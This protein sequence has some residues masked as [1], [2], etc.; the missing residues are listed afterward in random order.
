[1]ELSARSVRHRVAVAGADAEPSAG[2]TDG[3]IDI[4][5][6]F[7]EDVDVEALAS[8]QVTEMK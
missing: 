8:I 1:M 5:D 4:D 2:T 6:S 3:G 7:W